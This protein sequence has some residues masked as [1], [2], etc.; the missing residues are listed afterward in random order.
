MMTPSTPSQAMQLPG[1][2]SAIPPVNHK[3]PL[4]AAS[5]PTGFFLGAAHQAASDASS[6]NLG[7]MCSALP[8]SPEH[9]RKISSAPHDM[10]KLQGSRLGS[11]KSRARVSGAGG[12]MRRV[13]TSTTPLSMRRAQSFMWTM[14]VHRDF[15]SAIQT[16]VSRGQSVSD[17]SAGEVLA[18]MKHSGA[19]GLTELSVE[20]HLQ[21][22]ATLQ[23]KLS[24]MMP[25]PKLDRPRHFDAAAEEPRA[26]PAPAEAPAQQLHAMRSASLA[27]AM[28]RQQAMQRQIREQQR[29]IQQMQALDSAVATST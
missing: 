6:F 24:A 23:Q 14:D 7:K 2:P 1:G 18:L 26:M 10:H 15:E 3:S 27:E 25:P 19:N 17:I 4:I 20:R 16:L 12:P 13:A 5:S 21:K 28:Q 11:P 9:M 22:R 29:S 8:T